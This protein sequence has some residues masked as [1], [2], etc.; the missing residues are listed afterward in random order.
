MYVYW[1]EQ[2]DY[3]LNKNNCPQNKNLVKNYINSL[4]EVNDTSVYGSLSWWCDYYILDTKRKE[5]V[6]YD[7]NC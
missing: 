7:S 3:C 6:E 1:P 2:C 5:E 4:I